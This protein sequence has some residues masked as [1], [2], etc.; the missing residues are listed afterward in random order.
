MYKELLDNQ[1]LNMQQDVIAKFQ[2]YGDLDVRES[3]ILGLKV[4]FSADKSRYIREHGETSFF[5]DFIEY[6][7]MPVFEYDLEEK[8][9]TVM[10]YKKG[11]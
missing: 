4:I 3:A 1:I 11:V 5:L 2:E 8:E 7:I 6:G 10:F 9:Y